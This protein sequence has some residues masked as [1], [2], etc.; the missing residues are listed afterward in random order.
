M[1][2]QNANDKQP[3]KRQFPLKTILILA[4][5]LLLEAGAVS[6]VW[7]F[8]GQP[9]EVSADGADLDQAELEQPVEMELIADR[10]QN[11]R[12]GRAYLYDTEIYIIVANKHQKTVER[13]LGS[14]HAQITTEVATIFRRAEPAHLLE[15]ELS[16]LTRQIKAV[17]DEKV[18]YDE[19]GKPYVQQVLIRKCMQYPAS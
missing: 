7:F 18:G 12:S 4:V 15:P 5:I 17:M 13:K 6:A 11:T 19:E 16:T 1:A 3:A 14:M 8:A 10:F 2:E 9:P